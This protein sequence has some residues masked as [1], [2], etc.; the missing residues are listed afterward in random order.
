MVRLLGMVGKTVLEKLAVGCT[1]ILKS[2]PKFFET[3]A[4]ILVS[5]SLSSTP[6]CK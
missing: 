4:A 5:N 1:E 2:V 6:D 3:G